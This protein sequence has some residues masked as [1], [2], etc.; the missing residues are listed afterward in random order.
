MLG[1]Q[2]QVYQR[3]CFEARRS[4]VAGLERAPDP[5]GARRSHARWSSS[6]RRMLCR[7]TA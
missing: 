1:W 3:A 4:V 6:S 2:R 5:R 7:R